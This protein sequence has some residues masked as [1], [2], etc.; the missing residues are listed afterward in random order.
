MTI[1]KSLDAQSLILLLIESFLFFDK[2]AQAFL[3][4]RQLG[5]HSIIVVYCRRKVSKV[6]IGWKFAI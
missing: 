3:G 4:N 2:P 1:K 6:M 5:F